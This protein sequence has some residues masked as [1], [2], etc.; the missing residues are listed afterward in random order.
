MDQEVRLENAP[1]WYGTP[2]DQLRFEWSHEEEL[3]IERYCEKIL[4]NAS[5]EEMTPRQR[6]EA[7]MAGRKRDRLLIEALYFNPY[8]V[9]TLNSAADVLKPIDVCR[10][11]KLL[12]K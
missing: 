9:Q 5:A 10:N 12:V 3:E 8:A 2:L 11:P 1:N 7:T 6:F 4:K